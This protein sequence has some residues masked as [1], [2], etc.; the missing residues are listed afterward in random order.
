MMPEPVPRSATTAPSVT[1]ASI[2]RA[3]ALA[4]HS[5]A[6]IAP[7]A[8]S[9][10]MGAREV[11]EHRLADFLEAVDSSRIAKPSDRDAIG[12]PRHLVELT[13]QP[14]GADDATVECRLHQL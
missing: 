11:R 9:S 1:R 12:E 8:G 7:Y 3:Y 14:F 13:R 4:R 6:I 10:Y 2:A 5:S